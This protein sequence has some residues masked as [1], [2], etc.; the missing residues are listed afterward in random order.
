MNEN[1][2]PGSNLYFLWHPGTQDTFSGYGLT[3]QPGRKEQLA[4]LLMVDRPQPVDP[5]WLAEVKTTFGGYD[6]Y[7]MTATH[8]RGIACQMWV[9][10][11]S[12]PYLRQF[13]RP[14]TTRVAQA[15]T[16]L[17]QQPPKP[18][19]KV[20]WDEASRLWVSEFQK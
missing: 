15:L 6:L 12:L 16:P 3:V 17:L 18:R 20:H 14:L 10:K 7:M 2:S 4:G 9:E 5:A 19:F 1:T 11:Q 8:E 13:E